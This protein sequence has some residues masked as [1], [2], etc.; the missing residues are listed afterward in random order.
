MRSLPSSPEHST[1][2]DWNTIRTLLPYLLEYK[3]RVALALTLLVLAKLANVAVPL[4]L[5]EIVD[6]MDK[7]RAML[8]V[9]VF[10]VVGYGL[11]RLFST[12]FGELRDAVFV[13]VTQRAATGTPSAPCCPTCWSS[14]G[15][16][17]WR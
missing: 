1:R 8:L 17:C 13:K 4:L 16:S 6:A 2:G 14:R 9:P 10:L 12:L 5:K 11:L 3:A 15:A 7:P